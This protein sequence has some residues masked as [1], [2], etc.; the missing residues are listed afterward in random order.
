M[1]DAENPAETSDSSATATS[2]NP[3]TSPGAPANE[4]PTKAPH[5]SG[6]TLLRS[7]SRQSAASN[8]RLTQ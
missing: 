5:A 8:Q 4:A 7:A 2:E 3:G 6:R 1:L